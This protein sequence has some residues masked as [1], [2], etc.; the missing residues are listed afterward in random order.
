MQS[1]VT[2]LSDIYLNSHDISELCHTKMELKYNLNKHIGVSVHAILVTTL[3]STWNWNRDVNVS[4]KVTKQSSFLINYFQ[5]TIFLQLICKFHLLKSLW[6]SWYP[7]PLF[8][9]I[10]LQF[11]Y[12]QVSYKVQHLSLEVFS[13]C[14]RKSRNMKIDVFCPVWQ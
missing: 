1:T 10:S 8:P 14:H 7:L 3:H 5:I 12:L 4:M 13:W 6:D 9:L 11:A 2:S